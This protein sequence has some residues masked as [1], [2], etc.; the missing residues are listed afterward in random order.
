MAFGSTSIP[1]RFTSTIPDTDAQSYL[2]IHISS[3]VPPAELY[4][5]P[6][7]PQRG[8]RAP[9]GPETPA[10]WTT[11]QR[12]SQADEGG[13]VSHWLFPQAPWP[14]NRFHYR[15]LSCGVKPGLCSERHCL[16]LF[17]R[18]HFGAGEC[19][20]ALE[21]HKDALFF[22]PTRFAFSVVVL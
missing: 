11:G 7:P 9:G 22:Y 19:S 4:H 8:L 21:R 5:T 13:A 16:A 17:L 6:R 15:A 10:C 1:H 2:P 3:F 12:Q 14:H 20:G 18:P